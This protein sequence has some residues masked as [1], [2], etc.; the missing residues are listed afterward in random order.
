MATRKIK[1]AKDLN[2]GELIYFKGHARATFLSDGRNMEEAISSL[3]AGMEDTD[4][5]VEDVV[6]LSGATPVVDHGTSD[7]TFTLTSGVI[8]KWGVVSNLTLNIPE[9]SEGEVKQY[10]VVM[11]IGMDFTLSLPDTLVWDGITNPVFKL[12]HTYPKYPAMLLYV[13]M[14][15]HQR[16]ARCAYRVWEQP[17]HGPLLPLQSAELLPIPLR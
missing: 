15:H 6:A 14:V 13:G 17:P 5:T 1:D 4:E 3:N 12:F 16:S 10:R 2:T 7:T 11:T 9:D 8:H